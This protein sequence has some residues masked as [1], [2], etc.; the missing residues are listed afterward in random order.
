MSS[1]QEIDC[2]EIANLYREEDRYIFWALFI[3]ETPV[4]PRHSRKNIG[5]SGDISSWQE[6][7]KIILQNYST[8]FKLFW[9][10]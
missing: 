10:P 7:V 8:K 3:L 5:Q 4:D 6:F 1:R 2:R 9:E